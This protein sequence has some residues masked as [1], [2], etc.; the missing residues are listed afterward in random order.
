MRW[1]T[2]RLEAQIVRISDAIAYLAHDLADAERDGALATTD[3]PIEIRDAL[4]DAHSSRLNAMVCDV[5]DSSWDCTGESSESSQHVWIRMSDAM[6]DVTTRLRDFMFER[7]YHP[8]SASPEGVR[9]HMLRSPT[10]TS[11]IPHTLMT[12]RSGCESS[13]LNPSMP[14]PIS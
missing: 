4:G 3:V 8:T 10:Y 6:I 9:A 7:V 14:P 11:T 5:V 1:R 12:F 2:C 13:Q